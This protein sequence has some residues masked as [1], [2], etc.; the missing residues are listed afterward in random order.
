[1]DGIRE[2]PNSLTDI[3]TQQYFDELEMKVGH[4]SWELDPEGSFLLWTDPQP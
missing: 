3:D 4:E 1:M 2:L